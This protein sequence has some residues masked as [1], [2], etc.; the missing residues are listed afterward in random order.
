MN[1]EV[2]VAWL[3]DFNQTY[4]FFEPR[5]RRKALVGGSKLWIT[6]CRN[7]GRC[8]LLSSLGDF[9]DRF[10]RRSETPL[11][12]GLS[13]GK[14][15]SKP[16]PNQSRTIYG[17]WMSMADKM[18]HIYHPQ[19]DP[20]FVGLFF[21][22]LFYS[23]YQVPSVANLRLGPAWPPSCSCRWWLSGTGDGVR[24]VGPRWHDSLFSDTIAA[25]I[26]HMS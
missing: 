1:E 9:P 13:Y 15:P 23:G 25:G 12:L 8:C 16:V 5:K 2:T 4:D 21:S 22:C 7:H 10:Q 17:L 19:M 6:S 3:G 18:C 14:P 24:G 11:K 20:N 26:L